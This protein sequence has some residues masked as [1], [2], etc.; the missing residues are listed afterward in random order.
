MLVE[1]RNGV[2][3]CTGTRGTYTNRLT[4]AEESGVMW[5]AMAHY[6]PIISFCESALLTGGMSHKNF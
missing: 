6:Y 1:R 5:F 2:V 3:I 4:G